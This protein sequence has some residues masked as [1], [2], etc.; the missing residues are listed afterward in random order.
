MN[1]ARLVIACVFACLLV[2]HSIRALCITKPQVEFYTACGTV[3]GATLLLH[4][5]RAYFMSQQV[6]ELK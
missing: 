2:S 5:P 6:V 3:S 1:C 4:N